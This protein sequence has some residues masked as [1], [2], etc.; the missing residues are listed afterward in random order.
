LRLRLSKVELKII[1]PE[2]EF[3]D[4]VIKVFAKFGARTTTLPDIYP[5]SDTVE[6]DVGFQPDSLYVAL[7]DRSENMKVD[8]KIF[9]KWGIEEEGISIERPE[10]EIVLLTRAGE[11]QNLEYK[12]QVDSEDKKNDFIESV[13]AFLNT[14]RGI[15]MIGVDDSG[16]IVGCK[17]D[18][19]DIHNM[20]HDR[21]DPPPRNIKVERKSIAENDV[22]IVEVPEGDNKPYQSKRD[23]KWYIRHNAN[24][25]EME[26]SEL[27]QLLEKYMQAK[28]Y[29]SL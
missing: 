5:K 28:T 16:N 6:F 15:I 29:T 9:T 14:N 2:I 27:F 11:S 17:K 22:L 4:L 26:R 12:Y 13:I 18:P 8:G 1:S 20:I 25:M 21:C 10:E 24:D 7:L 23:K 19:E 3:K